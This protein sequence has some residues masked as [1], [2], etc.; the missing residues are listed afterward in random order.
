MNKK[1]VIF[2]G[3]ILL[4]IAL[5]IW[6][7]ITSSKPLPGEKIAA[8]CDN[9]IDFSKLDNTNITD[10]CRVHVPDGTVVNYSTNPP[11]FGPHYPD[12]ISKGFY[13]EPRFDGNLIHSQEHG[14]VIIWYD[15]EQ[16]VTGNR[17]QFTGTVYAQGIGMTQGSEGSPSAKLSD[18]PKSFSD[19]S[20][21]NLKKQLKDIYQKNSHKLIVMP[22]AG[23]DH[24]IILTAWGRM[25]KLNS[26][27]QGKIKEF[28]DAYRDF[29][30]EATN[31]P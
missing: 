24:P 19:G 27:D 12:W 31:E 20:C 8:N 14:Y 13:D 18:M 11:V 9:S 15:C 22:R 7:L 17:L 10:K 16:K 28:I 21:D 23:M 1:W 5:L 26:L 29:G 30:P 3:L 4:F 25:E 6:L 2:A